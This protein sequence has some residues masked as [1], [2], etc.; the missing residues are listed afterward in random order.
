MKFLFKIS[1]TSPVLT[2]NKY[3]ILIKNHIIDIQNEFNVL[4]IQNNHK[5]KKNPNVLVSEN[6]KKG[7]A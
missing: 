4:D 6:T 1:M 5:H 2:S 3:Y 7:E